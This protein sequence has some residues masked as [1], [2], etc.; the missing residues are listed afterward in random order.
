MAETAKK[1]TGG[2]VALS[3][4][5]GKVMAVPTMASLTGAARVAFLRAVEGASGVASLSG[6]HQA[7]IRKAEAE[8]RAF[9]GTPRAAKPKKG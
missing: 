2:N 3:R 4:R 8:A 1:R 5:V 9:G 6:E 7:L